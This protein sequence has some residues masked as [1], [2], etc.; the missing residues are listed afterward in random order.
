MQ[1]SITHNLEAAR[2]VIEQA[3]QKFGAA[4]DGAVARGAV[5]LANRIKTRAPKFTSQMT[6]AVLPS[7]IAPLHHVVTVGK[8]YASYVENG[9]NPGGRPAVST[10]ERWIR[11]KGISPRTPGVSQRSLAHLIRQSIAA[12]GIRP[13]PF[14]AP[15]AARFE[16]RLTELIGAALDRVAADLGGR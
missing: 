1:I 16:G 11:L 14:V 15:A 6:N 4:V 10:I 5:E 2:Q 13:Q 9:S 8:A 7:R 3:P 12:K